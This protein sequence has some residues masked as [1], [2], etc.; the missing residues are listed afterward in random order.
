MKTNLPVFALANHAEPE[1]LLGLANDFQITADGWVQITP[2]G[3]FPHSGPKDGRGKPLFKNGVIQR[4]DR[5]AGENMVSEFNAAPGMF[6]PKVKGERPWYRGHHDQDP[7]KYPDPNS[8]GWI[9]ELANRDDGLYGKVEWTPAGQKLIDDKAFKYHSPYWSS[10]DTGKDD[11]QG[12]RIVTPIRLRSSAFTNQPNIPVMP[13]SNEEEREESADRSIAAGV[14]IDD[15]VARGVLV[16]A[17]RKDFHDYF[18]ES[19][20]DAAWALA[21]ADR[22]EAARKGWIT[23]RANA[24]ARGAAMPAKA[25]RI[26]RDARDGVR[27]ASVPLNKAELDREGHALLKGRLERDE[28][29]RAV[30][31]KAGGGTKGKGSEVSR[32]GGYSIKK[33]GAALYSVHHQGH[34]IGSGGKRDLYKIAAA[35]EKNRDAIDGVAKQLSAPPKLNPAR[36]AAA[37]KETAESLR[38]QAASIRGERPG[39]AARIDSAAS[40]HEPLTLTPKPVN[41]AMKAVA[42]GKATVAE[43]ANKL[44]AGTSK[45]D[46]KRGLFAALSRRS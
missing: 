3:D 32:S 37:H 39:I 18:N 26:A 10:A 4:M 14:L 23:R 12:R 16:E 21:N 36:I 24:A 15:A 28:Q 13:L 20:T 29:G 9:K 46:F 42:V 1:G 43:G 35:H 44:P 30:W 17:D 11:D 45:S 40:H 41:P 31:R 34:I 6:Q 22:S 8:Y 2:F 5:S 25:A 19:F 27:H 38:S 7:I 33:Q